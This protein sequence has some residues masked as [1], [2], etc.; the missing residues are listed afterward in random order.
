MYARKL[1]CCVLVV[2]G[3]LWLTL[4][5]FCPMS[6]QRRLYHP[7]DEERFG[8]FY[9]SGF[10]AVCDGKTAFEGID[11]GKMAVLRKRESFT[12]TYPLSVKAVDACY[13]PL[14]LDL[15]GIFPLSRGGAVA[16]TGLGLLLLLLALAE[17]AGK[18][19]ACGRFALLPVLAAALSACVLFA[20]Q[21]GNPIGYA[22]AGVALFCAWYDSECSW[23]RLTA[24]AA[25]GFAAVL[26]VSPVL[27]AALYFLP[28][29][30]E[31]AFSGFRSLRA[32]KGAA[33]VGVVGAVF[34]IVPFLWHGGADGVLAWIAGAGRHS[35]ECTPLGA[36]GV[37][38]IDWLVRLVL[39]DGIEGGWPTYG[40]SRALGVLLGCLCLGGAFR[41]RGKSGRLFF[42]AAAL[43]L[44]AGNTFAYG[45][46]Y[47]LPAF[48]LWCVER[49]GGRRGPAMTCFECACWFGML[50]PLQIPLSTGSVNVWLLP[51]S[52]LALTV[53][54]VQECF[55]R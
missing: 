33:L 15:L 43:L 17:V 46:L 25:L 41:I 42:L 16:C 34:G 38:R 13:P 31:G 37:T 14:A 5:L 10:C 19:G 30:A 23:K 52:F 9:S 22:A 51:V 2:A 24:A 8:D 50:C 3:V 35:A 4:A 20:F 21:R 55:R 18:E 26:K 53:T 29:E 49:N 44:L 32:W 6:G 7:R 11:E 40:I 45:A 27:F 39:G 47:L 12:E 36:F 28:R 48:V 54:K 1:F